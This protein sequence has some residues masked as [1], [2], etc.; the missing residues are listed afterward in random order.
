[1]LKHVL[2]ALL[3]VLAFSVASPAAA[4]VARK[5][6][7]SS[8]KSKPGSKPKAGA[9]LKPGVKSKPGR[10]P[11][12]APKPKPGQEPAPSLE[13]DPSPEPVPP[14]EDP[15]SPG[16]APSPAPPVEALP[17]LEAPPSPEPPTP[18]A[19]PGSP[20]QDPDLEGMPG[21]SEDPDVAGMPGLGE[22]PRVT[23][24]AGSGLEESG[25]SATFRGRFRTQAS[26]DVASDL[27]GED[28]VESQ[29]SLE[30][31]ADLRLTSSLAARLSGR[32][33]Y[34]LRA[35]ER[36][37]GGGA[38]AFFDGELRDAAV[39]LSWGRA[40]LEIGQQVLRWGSTEVNSPNDILNPI[41]FR[42]GVSADFETP[43]LPI[44]L[45]R[46]GYSGDHVGGELVYVPFFYPHRGYAFGSDWSLL[47][48]QPALLGL[49]AQ[50]GALPVRTGVAEE[51]LFA[52]NAPSYM[53]RHGSV[54][55]RA[56]LRGA[57]W[58]VRL[59]LFYGWDRVPEIVFFPPSDPPPPAPF[60]S[61]F[62]RE[63]GVGLDGSA[64]LGDFIFR[65][66]ARLSARRTF[67]TETLMPVRSR[68]LSW[69]G[70]VEFRERLLLEAY[71]IW[72]LDRSAEDVPLLLL[73]RRWVNAAL[74]YRD[75]FFRERLKVNAGLQYGFN[76]KDWAVSGIIGY[77][78]HTGH[79]LA[80][81]AMVLEG[82]SGSLSGI[83]DA[84]DYVF[85]RYTF[86]F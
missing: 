34:D 3:L 59:N 49:L 37:F 2:R 21:L 50:A 40:Q 86:S 51:A 14:P 78:V 70:G 55:G 79:E 54:G 5:R 66:D 77:D 45:V 9:R 48:A 82:P 17:S 33:F 60:S 57:G 1:M 31:E 41:D 19:Q 39:S 52:P 62:H 30:F 44:P 20:S 7:G 83:F 28:L 43:L 71:G 73:D 13:S 6:P 63:L 84:N 64:V 25:L 65:V 58:D 27:P 69:A 35:P 11:K 61:T 38:R 22:G 67:Y 68:A 24:P 29:S 85:G 75:T 36:T 18:A 12:S 42:R 81:G 10:K 23:P 56:F 8:A 53:P 46:A 80:V 15:S 47:V 72:D 16:P 74:V 32:L 76:R 26:A 4:E